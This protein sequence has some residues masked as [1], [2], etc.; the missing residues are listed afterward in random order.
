MLP[1]LHNVPTDDGTRAELETLLLAC[2]R[3][4]EAARRKLYQTHYAL[5]LSVARRYSADRAE[6]EELV[7]DAF[8]KLFRLLAEQPFTGNFEGYFRRIVV[9]AGIDHYRVQHRRRD[10]LRGWLPLNDGGPAENDALNQLDE[11]DVLQFIQRLSPGY[12][13][14]FNLYVI[15]GLT[16][17][18]IAKRLGITVSTSK[19]NLAKARRQLQKSAASYFFPEIRPDHV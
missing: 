12:R 3:Q 17:P 14:V 16:H 6:A 19:S 8:L 2:H 1:E 18:E 11:Q 4:E 13:I 7:H 10:L 9:N 15:E 5:A